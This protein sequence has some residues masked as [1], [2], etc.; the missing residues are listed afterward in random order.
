[1][2]VPAE[3]PDETVVRIFYLHGFGSSPQSGKAAFLRD[4]LAP[5]GIGLH[6]PDFNQ[7]DF[8]SLTATRMLAQLSA[9]IDALPAEPVAL[10]GSSLGGF[11]AIHAAAGQAAGTAHPITRLILLAPAVD[12]ASGRDGW[13]TDAELDDWLRT[14]RRDV[15]HH[16]YGQTLP[17]GWALYEDAHGYDAFLA[18]FDIPTL[19]F[20]GTGDTVVNP[21]RVR[22]WAA[23]RRN[24]TL[25][26]VDDTHQLQASLEAIWQESA[27][28]LGLPGE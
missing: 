26:M 19:A 24:V 2:S 18:T 17:L 5:L 13:L 23:P 9:A 20:Q 7:P 8:T 3:L 10:I 14:N 28:F 12:F 11:V 6:A 21:E 27:P 22:A 25:R 4:R 1:V 16:A 15:F